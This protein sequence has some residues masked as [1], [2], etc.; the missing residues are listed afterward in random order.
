[1]IAVYEYQAN[2]VLEAN[3]IGM[4][5]KKIKMFDMDFDWYFSSHEF[6]GL[7]LSFMRGGSGEG[8]KSNLVIGSRWLKFENLRQIQSSAQS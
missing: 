1:M 3:H 8:G 6:R 5:T 7:R 4:D 2:A